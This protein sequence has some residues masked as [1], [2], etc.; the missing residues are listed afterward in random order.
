MMDLIVKMK[1][2]SGQ[3]I[4]VVNIITD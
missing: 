3:P 1:T 2:S 4:Q